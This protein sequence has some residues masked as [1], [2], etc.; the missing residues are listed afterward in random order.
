[1]EDTMFNLDQFFPQVAKYPVSTCSHTSTLASESCSYDL[2]ELTRGLS[3]L[4]CLFLKLGND[5]SW[6][7]FIGHFL[8]VSFKGID[9]KLWSV[10]IWFAFYPVKSIYVSPLN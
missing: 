6:S 8:E 3:K 1:M 2:E 10:E 5:G 7:H 9:W 4:I